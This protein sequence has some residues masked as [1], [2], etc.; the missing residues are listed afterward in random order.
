MRPDLSTRPEKEAWI[1]T[2]QRLLADIPEQ[3]AVFQHTTGTTKIALNKD[4]LHTGQTSIDVPAQ[5]ALTIFEII[6]GQENSALHD[7]LHLIIGHNAVVK[8]IRLHQGDTTSRMRRQ[9]KVDLQK[10][11]HYQQVTINTNGKFM[12]T[13]TD[14]TAHDEGAHADVKCVSL[15]ANKTQADNIVRTNF[16]APHCTANTQ[17]KNIVNDTS[18]A[19]FQGKF[20]VDASAQKTDAYM[21]CQNL[22]LDDKS[23]T[24]MKPELEIYADDVKCSHGATTGAL[25]PEQLF[26]LK[27]RGIAEFAAKKLLI[28]GF[29]LDI[30]HETMLDA[31]TIQLTEDVILNWL[32]QHV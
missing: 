28:Q 25:D 3:Q 6:H 19:V 15:L 24:S 20:Y 21:L 22:L 23:Q 27:S 4:T 14:I 10:E 13:E 31:D 8:H 17:Q 9:L 18:H 32:D 12:R 7:Q 29:A 16:M 2:P 5:E 26:Y 1:F 30:L 11:A